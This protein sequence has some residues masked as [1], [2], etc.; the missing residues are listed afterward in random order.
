MTGAVFSFILLC[1]GGPACQYNENFGPYGFSTL[2]E[3]KK[4]ARESAL[5]VSRQTGD[6]WAFMCVREEYYEVP[7]P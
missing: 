5:V 3:C 4:T 2:D 6:V 1:A 7:R